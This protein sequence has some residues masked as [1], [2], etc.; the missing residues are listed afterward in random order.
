MTAWPITQCFDTEA[1]SLMPSLDACIRPRV[2]QPV[3]TDAPAVAVA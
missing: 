1:R 3:G 2:K